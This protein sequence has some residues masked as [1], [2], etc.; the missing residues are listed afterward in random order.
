VLDVEI[1]SAC[2]ADRDAYERIAEHITAKD[3]TPAVGFWLDLV[4][5]WYANDTTANKVDVSVLSAT[6]ASRIP[7]PKQ[8]E[9]IMGVLADLPVAS[10]PDNTARAALD[11]LRRNAGL[12]L[13]GAIAANDDKKQRL[14]LPR[15]SDL[16]AAT[17]LVTKNRPE[18]QDA[19][20]IREIFKKVGQS[21]R[22][23]LA[24]TRLN[25]HIN[26]GALPGHHIVVFGR[27]EMGKSSFSVNLATVMAANGQRVLYVGNEDQIDNLKARALAR[28]ANMTLEQAE[29]DQ[30][31]AFAAYE[32]RGLEDRLL[33]SQLSKGSVDALRA[34]VE[35]WK[36]TVLVIDQIRNLES[37]ED[38]LPARL[39][40]NGQ[41]V[42]RLLL[43]YGLIGISVTQAGGSAE[44]KVWLTMNDMDSSKTGLPGT[45]DL[46][47]GVG[48]NAD[49][50]AR[51]QRALSFPKN[52]LSSAE[53][54]HEGII[55]EIDH[56]RSS[57]K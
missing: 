40:Y 41:M 17:N 32:R 51:G 21:N 11:L 19:V 5:A 28:A 20:P 26:G 52:K 4:K 38:G 22:I 7:N 54:A 37:G 35:E 48:G 16:C 24:P 50:M 27:P 9:T 14:I 45:A 12:E 56:S 29:N 15:Y 46:I 10:S 44:G 33:F 39:E 31:A 3:M 47:I 30:E 25:A 6:G 2:I 53:N 49:M 23:P 43:D 36:P 13:A 57:F 55:V 1:L 8:R 18:W 42:R 34:R